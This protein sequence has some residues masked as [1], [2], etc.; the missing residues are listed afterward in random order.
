[1]NGEKNDSDNTLVDV[2][3]WSR[4][5]KALPQKAMRSIGIPLSL[6]HVEVSEENLGWEDVQ[7]TQ[8]GVWIAG[9]EYTLARM[10][11]LSS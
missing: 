11:F 9:K 8:T 1:M 6:E 4:C 10:H 7:W 3:L 5:K 2:F